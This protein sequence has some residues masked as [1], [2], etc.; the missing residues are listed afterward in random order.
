[1]FMCKRHWFMLPKATR[2][3]IWDVYIP[4]QEI[5]KD[6]TDEYMAVAMDAIDW[7]AARESAP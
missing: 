5:R 7:L 3:A 2:D 1:M 4:G 6:P